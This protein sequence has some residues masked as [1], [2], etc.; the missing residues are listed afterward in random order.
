[1]Q[2][3]PFKRLILIQARDHGILGWGYSG[4]SEIWPN[5]A[6]ILKL[7]TTGFPEDYM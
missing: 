7:K 4:D 2:G 6:C 5:S 1:M 3:G